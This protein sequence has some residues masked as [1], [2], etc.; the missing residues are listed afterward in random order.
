MLPF[1]S[2]EFYLGALCTV[3]LIYVARNIISK[4]ISFENLILILSVAFGAILYPKP[5][6]LFG[7]VG[8]SYTT[9]YL[10]TQK[11]KGVHRL[12]G[13]LIIALPLILIKVKS[14]GGV[15][16][17]AGASYMT[18]R[19]I[20]VFIDHEQVK[21]EM[22]FKRFVSFLIFVPTLLVGPIDRF[23]RFTGDLKQGFSQI[24]KENL[25]KGWN[26]VLLGLIQKYVF[27]VAVNRFWLSELDSSSTKFL[28]MVENMFVYSAYLYFDFAGYS[29]LAMGLGTMLGIM[30]P[31]N[32]NKPYLSI[33][34]QDFWKRWHITLGDWLRDYFFKP[35]Y[36]ELTSI[37][38]LRT[39]PLLKQNVSLFLTFALMGCWNGFELK[40]IVSGCTFGLYSAIHNSYNHYSR[41]HKKDYLGMLPDW[42]A[43]TISI[44][45]MLIFFSFALYI[46][47][48]RFPYI[49]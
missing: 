22:S 38:K 32:F 9:L 3:L 8:Y 17:F 21:K 1:S 20:Q 39:W 14:F 29:Y 26:F 28:D 33:N 18:F 15:I 45:L 12:L 31:A 36:K 16:Q 41:K 46:F 6:H 19:T 30:V 5:L 23:E 48:G 37:Q 7:F 2:I 47:S 40:Y 35:I 34:P 44:G 11:C 25:L 24:N 4:F 10:L 27:A 42:M 49:N 13:S 43:K